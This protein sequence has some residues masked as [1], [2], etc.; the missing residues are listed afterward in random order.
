MT[1][2][3]RNLVIQCTSLALALRH[4]ARLPLPGLTRVGKGPTP[5]LDTERFSSLLR[6]EHKLNTR[7]VKTTHS[8]TLGG[9]APTLLRNVN[10]SRG[11]CA[12]S[13]THM[14]IDKDCY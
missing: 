4:S 1:W 13:S 10:Q 2:C 8:Y 14:L 7:P 9:S 3:F 5:P 6:P 12:T 11:L